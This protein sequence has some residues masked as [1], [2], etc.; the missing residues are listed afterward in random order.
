MTIKKWQNEGDLVLVMADMNEDV[1]LPLIQ[2]TF[3]TVGLVERLTTQ[4]P[5]PPPTHNH[6]SNP[7]NG[8]FIPLS[9]LDHCQTGYLEFGVAVPSDHRALWINIAA[10]NVCSMEPEP[11]ECPKA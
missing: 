2:N 11:I 10:H 1:R 9:L 6:G 3:R 5:R 7:I 8:I 4:H